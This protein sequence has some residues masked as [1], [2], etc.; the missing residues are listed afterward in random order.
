MTIVTPWV[1]PQFLDCLLFCNTGFAK[2]T[3]I[4]TVLFSANTCAV[5]SVWRKISVHSYWSHFKFMITNLRC[6][7]LLPG[8]YTVLPQCIH[9][10]TLLG[11]YFILYT[12][13]LKPLSYL[14][15][16]DDLASSFT[17]RLK[18]SADNLPKFTSPHLPPSHR[19]THVVF[20]LW[21]TV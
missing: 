17:E 11:N 7:L 1:P 20:F 16:P 3:F 4:I 8:K 18:R 6:H 19:W 10:S 14:V 21:M 9:S 13:P 15:S 5:Q 2:L 12:F